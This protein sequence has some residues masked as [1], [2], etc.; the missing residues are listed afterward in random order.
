M[1]DSGLNDKLVCE[2]CG[3]IWYRQRQRGRKPRNCPE[4]AK[5][6]A[7]EKA[8]GVPSSKPDEPLANQLARLQLGVT[9]LVHQVQAHGV[10]TPPPAKIGKHERDRVRYVVADGS[11]DSGP[12]LTNV[13]FAFGPS[14]PASAQTREAV[15]AEVRRLNAIEAETHSPNDGT[16]WYALKIEIIE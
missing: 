5:I 14:A 13:A 4:C 3:R 16:R 11:A 12:C 10:V 2:R 6:L 8:A 7:D 1:S 15:T 9:D